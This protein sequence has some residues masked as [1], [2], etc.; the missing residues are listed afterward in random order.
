M[1]KPLTTVAIV[2]AGLLIAGCSESDKGS[3]PAST[4]TTSTTATRPPVAQPALD[5]LLPTPDEVN[6]AMG[7]T[8]MA[9]QQNATA[10][11]TDYDKKWPPECFF[12]S[13]SAEDPAYANSGFTAVRL[14]VVGAPA[15]PADQNAAP[16]SATTG[17]V[18]FPS[19]KEASAFFTASAQ[20]WAACSDRQWTVPP[21]GANDAEQR[22]QTKPLTN[23]NG[24]LSLTLTGSIVGAG[25]NITMTCQ[26]ALTVRNNVAIDINTCGKDP[27]DTAVTIANQ[28]GGKVDKL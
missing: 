4:T 9:V 27:G 2:A 26:R 19:S 3:G 7:V 11:Q 24:V 8:G 5:G 16:P 13:G 25:I 1:H 20:K 6:A 15:P 18:L 14:Q 28:V 12:A 21:E 17:L 23:A 10:M 22:M